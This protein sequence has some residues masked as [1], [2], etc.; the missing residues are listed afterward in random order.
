MAESETPGS[1]AKQ[2]APVNN[3][4]ATAKAAATEARQCKCEKLTL[5]R[6]LP[7]SIIGKIS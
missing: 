6:R 1:S 3:V 5:I 2:G 4:T 7:F